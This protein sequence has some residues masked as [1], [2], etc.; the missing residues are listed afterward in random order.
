MFTCL[1]SLVQKVLANFKQQYRS[2]HL[3]SGV[4]KFCLRA[5]QL[6]QFL[7]LI[8]SPDWFIQHR[9]ANYISVRSHGL[10]SEIMSGIN[11]LP[12][13]GRRHRARHEHYYIPY[14]L[15]IQCIGYIEEFF[16][17]FLM[18]TVSCSSLLE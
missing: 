9:S 5:K 13:V 12:V 4:S 8:A 16:G 18:Q 10:I 11:D 14:M 2:R 3:S 17:I 1:R 6:S 7:R 15:R